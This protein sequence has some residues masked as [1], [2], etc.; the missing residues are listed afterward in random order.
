MNTARAVAVAQIIEIHMTI[1]RL[2]I[3]VDGDKFCD[4][5]GRAREFLIDDPALEFPVEERIRRVVRRIKPGKC[6]SVPHW[7]KDMGVTRVLAGGIGSVAIFRL[8]ELGIAVSSGLSGT[9]PLAILRQWLENP[10]K[11]D[12]SPCSPDARKIRHCQNGSRKSDNE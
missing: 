7:L 9:D 4:H 1:E 10:N 3:P 6:E 5:F 2:A 11:T 12:A 8:R